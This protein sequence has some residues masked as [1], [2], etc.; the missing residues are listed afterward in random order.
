M[1][2]IEQ[3]RAW[4]ITA[5]VYMGLEGKQRPGRIATLHRFAVNGESFNGTLRA[6]GTPMGNPEPVP[7]RTITGGRP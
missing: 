2:F 4:A 7:L 3:C 6:M 5:A 1:D